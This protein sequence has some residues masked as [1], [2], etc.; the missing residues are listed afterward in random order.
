MRRRDEPMEEQNR[1]K[2]KKMTNTQ[3]QETEAVTGREKL[4]KEAIRK[5]ETQG[6]IATKPKPVEEKDT[7]KKKNKVK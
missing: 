7:Q 2:M 6:E 1:V 4:G 3:K 5:M